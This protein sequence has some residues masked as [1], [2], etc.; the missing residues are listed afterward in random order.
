[1]YIKLPLLNNIIGDTKYEKLISP[2]ATNLILNLLKTLKL[3][4]IALPAFLCEEVLFAIKSLKIKLVFYQ[5][6]NDFSPK[7]RKEHLDSDCLYLCD[8]FGL[9]IKSSTNFELYFLETNKP[10]LFD[11]SHSL[12]AGAEIC[13]SDF[14]QK[15]KNIF[16]IYSLRKFFPTLNGG[17]LI[18]KK[19]PPLFSS[20]ESLNG[21][22]N[23]FQSYIFS[24]LKYK[25][26]SF[27]IGRNLLIRRKLRIL[28]SQELINGNIINYPNFYKENL[29]L[30]YY[31]KKLDIR[32]KKYLKQSFLKKLSEKRSEDISAIESLLS[33]VISLNYFQKYQSKIEYGVPYG[34]P[35]I[36]K[37]NLSKNFLEKN[38]TTRFLRLN[39]K[40]EV[41][42]WPYNNTKIYSIGNIELKSVLFLMPRI[43]YV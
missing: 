40:T 14:L 30:G 7:L 10:I 26:A 31:S 16:F 27:E 36:F 1:M 42:L 19:L 4:S 3:D 24:Y 25:L 5:L 22:N 28:N 39:N 15:R 20:F 2:S 9:P 43:S 13:S 17:L 11:R 41:I 12:L 6:D 37:G 21:I 23:P 35:I 18:S 29:K 38:F 34:I 8:Y 32:N 33:E